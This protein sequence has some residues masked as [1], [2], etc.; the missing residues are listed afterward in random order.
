MYYP[1]HPMHHFRNGRSLLAAINTAAT[2]AGNFRWLEQ[3]ITNTKDATI[4]AESDAEGRATKN[5]AHWRWLRDFKLRQL[6]LEIMDI[7]KRVNDPTST[8]WMNC[9]MCMCKQ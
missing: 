2:I 3:K 1:L 9:M 4:N 5:G 7:H 8:S 6:D